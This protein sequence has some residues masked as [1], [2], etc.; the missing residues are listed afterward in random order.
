MWWSSAVN[1]SFHEKSPVAILHNEWIELN[2]GDVAGQ[3]LAGATG[4]K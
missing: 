1:F 3:R 4:K 2:S